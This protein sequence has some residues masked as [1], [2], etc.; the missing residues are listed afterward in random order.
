MSPKELQYID[1]ALGHEQFLLSQCRQ[2]VGMLQDQDLKNCVNQ[3]LNKHQELF[4]RFY[5]LV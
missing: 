4:N 2:A 5:G 1:D 3:M